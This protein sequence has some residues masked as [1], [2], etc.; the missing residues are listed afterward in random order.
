MISKFYS[1]RLLSNIVVHMQSKYQKDWIKTEGSHS[2]WKQSWQDGQTTG[3]SALDKLCYVSSGAKN[4]ICKTH[5]FSQNI[6]V[7]I[8]RVSCKKG[9]THHAYA[10]QIGP[11]WQDTLDIRCVEFSLWLKCVVMR[12]TF[13]VISDNK[14]AILTTLIVPVLRCQFTGS[15]FWVF[16]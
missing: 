9:P 3:G 15:L 12:T 11:F 7:S 5:H 1:H 2:I 6:Q 4:I 13:T 10:W 8:S 14:V 16:W